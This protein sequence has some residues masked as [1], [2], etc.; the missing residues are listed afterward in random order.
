MQKREEKEGETEGKIPLTASMAH[1][2]RYYCLLARSGGNHHQIKLAA[3]AADE[4][5]VFAGDTALFRL[6]QKAAPAALVVVLEAAISQ[7]H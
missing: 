2:R 6:A 3:V 4:L 5:G 1:I 7:D